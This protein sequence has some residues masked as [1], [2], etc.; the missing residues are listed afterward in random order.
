MIHLGDVYYAGRTFEY[1]THLADIWPVGHAL[2]NKVGSWCLNGN[3]DMFTGGH[4]LFIFLGKDAR[5]RRQNG[6][7][8]FALENENWII[9]G[10]DTAYDC[11]G[12][13]GDEG[14][15]PVPQAGWMQQHLARVP[16]KKM[17]LLTHHQPFS[18]W[19][20][21]SPQLIDALAPVLR[22]R[23]PVEAWF[24]GHEHR[25]AVYEPSH[26]VTYPA[27]IGHAGVPVYASSKQPT[28]PK[29][30]YHDNRSFSHLLEKF[31]YMGFAVLDLDGADATVR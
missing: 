25:C 17:I 8:Y 10:L 29:L 27:L 11:I 16:G 12:L 2:G 23:K 26:N 1:E 4:A 31:S 30:R 19:E 14:T 6:C 20:N 22:R 9:F 5:F 21:D 24:W 15:L 13:K 3:H 18:A 28:G 7:T